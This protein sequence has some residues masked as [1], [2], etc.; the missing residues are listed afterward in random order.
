MNQQRLCHENFK[1]KQVG[2]V[3]DPEYPYLGAS[4]DGLTVCTCCGQG[5]LEIKCPYILKEIKIEE[6][7]FLNRAC[8]E[9]DGEII[10]LKRNHAYFYQIQ[11]QMKL[12]KTS[13]CDFVVWS[14]KQLFVERVE[15]SE[16]FWGSQFP[17]IE[18]FHKTVVLPELLGRYYTSNHLTTKKWCSCNG[19]D[20]GRPMI[21]C[22][23]DKCSTNWFHL[24]CVQL[25]DVPDDLWFCNFCKS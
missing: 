25:I 1:C 12:T 20:D 21:E 9:Y 7:A 24:D 5:C 6:Y 10:R 8:L 23:S 17:I 11:L 16:D 22:C 13:Y 19:L 18:K 2:L 15:F 4:P 3:I 14:P